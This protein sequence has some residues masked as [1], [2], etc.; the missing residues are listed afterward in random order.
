M[1][2]K[3]DTLINALDQHQTGSVSPADLKLW[4]EDELWSGNAVFKTKRFVEALHNTR[5]A[6]VDLKEKANIDYA[7]ESKKVL[8]VLFDGFTE[9]E[10][11]QACDSIVLNGA[12][13][14]AKMLDKIV[15]AL[16]LD[17]NGEISKDELKDWIAHET[18]F[19][20]SHASKVTTDFVPT[21]AAATAT[22]GDKKEQKTTTATPAVH[23]GA[24]TSHASLSS[25][26]AT[27]LQKKVD[28]MAKR[29][30]KNEDHKITGEE[31]KQY[32]SQFTLRE[33]R[34]LTSDLLRRDAHKHQLIDSILTYLDADRS[35]S[36]SSE[37]ISEWMGKS[38]LT[39][40]RLHG[41][42]NR[43]DSFFEK[44]GKRLTTLQTSEV[45][46]ALHS[47]DDEALKFL[48]DWLKNNKVAVADV[49]KRIFAA[50]DKNNDKLLD[51]SEISDWV[52]LEGD[53][54]NGSAVIKKKVDKLFANIDRNGDGKI[55]QEEFNAYFSTFTWSNLRRLTQAL[56]KLHP[57]IIQ[58]P[59][60]GAAT[61]TA[62]ATSSASASASTVSTAAATATKTAVATT[63]AAATT[64][65]TTAAT[66]AKTEEKK[67]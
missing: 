45:K 1:G 52:K 5:K 48:A 8:T 44:S 13:V 51:R 4:E 62:T 42:I 41:M 9:E 18:I 60:T 63:T 58:F 3:I 61:V 43:L 49:L 35:G 12:A 57:E 26:D 36:I 17:G 11:A 27:K 6:L 20:V 24:H 64:T 29:L 56:V 38:S 67:Q 65:T 25:V 32:F 39:N 46:W 19:Q 2:N 15:E 55:S 59:D 10:K 50:L 23:L 40:K 66:A 22:T 34:L 47:F 54:V 30:D 14:R 31:V 37:E 21:K 7:A 28:E 16:D 33:V 53:Y